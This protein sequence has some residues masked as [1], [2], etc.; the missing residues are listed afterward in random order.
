VVTGERSP[1]TPDAARPAPV[2]LVHGLWMDVVA[3]WPLGRRLARAHR[4]RP[5]GFRYASLR[6]TL[7]ENAASLSRA[8]DALPGE[9]VHF[10][11]HSLGGI[12]VLTM[13]ERCGWTRP[14]RVVALGS[15][16]L[17]SAVARAR[18][19]GRLFSALL[20]RGV[21]EAAWTVDR[22]PWTGPQ[23][24][25]VIAGSVPFGLGALLARIEKPHDGTVTVAETRLPG[26]ADHAVVPVTHTALL[27]SPTVADLTGRFLRTGRF[28]PAPGG[29]A[30]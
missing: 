21:Q 19:G 3:M 30:G 26:A 8:C 13:L 6:R 7:G 14:G 10:V 23:E 9:M 16:F 5:T 22:A 11:G 17:G 24:I 27:L 1:A 20:G 29:A 15:P 2:V 18:L 4:F 12:V 25:G 28:S